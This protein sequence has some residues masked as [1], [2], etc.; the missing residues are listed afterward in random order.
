MALNKSEPAFHELISNV[1]KA[2][3]II[4]RHRNKKSIDKYSALALACTAFAC[5]T[6]IGFLIS[7][8]R[9]G[10][11]NNIDNSTHNYYFDSDSGKEKSG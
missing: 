3:K 4:R 10:F 9:E 11:G 2:Q 6:V 1:R 5:G 7:P 8:A